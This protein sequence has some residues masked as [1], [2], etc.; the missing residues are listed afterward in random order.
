MKHH[1]I[2]PKQGRGHLDALLVAN[3]L[4]SGDQRPRQ[5]DRLEAAAMSI[6]Q[7]SRI[8]ERQIQSGWDVCRPITIEL[9]CL[10]LPPATCCAIAKSAY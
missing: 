6:L 7:G 5:G 4:E 2:G 1:A 8:V 10:L 9:D 3:S